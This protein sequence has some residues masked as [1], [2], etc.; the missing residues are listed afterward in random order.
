MASPAS[1]Y[2]FFCA[3]T[4]GLLLT[5]LAPAAHAV[6]AEATIQVLDQVDVF[7]STSIKRSTDTPVTLLDLNPVGIDLRSCQN[8]RNGLTCLDG[9]TVRNWKVPK[10]PPV[11]PEPRTLFS[12]EDDAFALDVRN[13]A[14]T[15]LTTDVR[16][17]IWLAGRKSSSSHNLIQV[18]RKAGATCNASTEGAP[19]SG[20]IKNVPY[21]GTDA[22]QYCFITRRSG[23]P[24]LLD[25]S[26]FDGELADRFRGRGILGVENRKTVVFFPS[27]GSPP[28]QVGAGK[29]DWSLVGNEQVQSAALLQREVQVGTGTR[30]LNYGLITTSTGRVMWKN[31]DLATSAVQVANVNSTLAGP[32]PVID[33]SS[34]VVSYPRGALCEANAS[35]ANFFEIRASDTTGRLFIGNR[36]YC[37]VF[38]ASPFY[39]SDTIVTL[40]PN[41]TVATAPTFKPE[42]I[43]VSPGIAIDLSNCSDPD[44]GCDFIKDGDDNNPD[45]TIAAASMTSVQLASAAS[46][47]IV[48]Q[49]K[50]IPDCRESSQASS[51]N[52]ADALNRGILVP[53]SKGTYLNVTPLLPQQ[54]KDLFDASGVR[55]TGLPPLLISPRYRAQAQNDGLFDALFGVTD[56]E[57]V[58]RKTFSVQFDIGD[59]NLNGQQLGCGVFQRDA[60]DP[61]PQQFQRWDIVTMVSERFTSVGGPTGTVSGPGGEHVDMLTNKDCFN[62]TK[63]AGTRWSMYAFNLQLAESDEADNFGVVKY[64]HAA[65]RRYLGNLLKSLYDD[66]LE[67]QTKLACSNVDEIGDTGALPTA[68]PLA[69][70]VCSNLQ[71]NWTGTKDKLFKCIDAAI[72]PKVS[73]LDQNC[74]AFNTQFPGYESYVAGLNPTGD[75]PANRVG[76]LAARLEVIRHVFYGH[77]LNAPLT[78]VVVP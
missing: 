44:V 45:Q 46:G 59:A 74:Q 29:N 20:R 17:S 69:T 63:G 56:P 34:G 19:L 73:Q 71:S 26:A 28:F 31:L 49:I 15:S 41:E 8:G 58:F 75:D 7:S 61:P 38:A 9:Q 33:T 42:G 12:C 1:G 72:D 70:G 62:P 36:N 43:S 2:S 37:K 4:I 66:L 6:T 57:V 50:N 47:L 13:G 21:A 24:L 51:P 32:D 3:I 60:A 55:P 76:E 10:A 52:C 35:R 16:G 30:V 39:A 54:I 40:T 67:A 65:P 64:T 22:A 53:S 48:F 25:I 78:Q 23:R 77:F 68:P 18:T 27:D 5:V 14:C 11:A